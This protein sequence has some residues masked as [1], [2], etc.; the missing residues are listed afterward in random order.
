MA[1]MGLVQLP[2]LAR[3][4]DVTWSVSVT[5]AR[6][7]EVIA[8]YDPDTVVDTAS[9][10]KLFLLHT[11]LAQVDAGERSLTD[12]LERLPVDMIDN[13]GLWWRMA[14]QHL[15]VYD[16]GLLIGAVS[17]NVATNVLLRSVGLE[18]VHAHTRRLGYTASGLD[19]KVRWPLP[20]GVSR[21]LSHASSRELADFCAR[22][23][24]REDLSAASVDVLTTW[25]S[26]ST[27]LSMV[28]SAFNFDPLAH[29]GYDRG[30]WL[31]NKTGTISTV[32]ADTGV[33]MTRNSQIAYAVLAQWKPGIDRRDD[34]LECMRSIGAQIRRAL[35]DDA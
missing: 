18:A 9:V 22:L 24:R 11:V 32:R 5:D 15:S 12:V 21:T 23:A 7:G 14:G 2:N 17:D 34:V 31:W 26:A 16:V 4:E 10:G 33:V 3:H 27:D 35:D 6:S 13:S 30:M 28:A 1:S 29:D 25:L 20:P 19:D 8:S